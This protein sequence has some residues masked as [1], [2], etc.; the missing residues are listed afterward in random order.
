MAPFTLE[1]KKSVLSHFL[2]IIFMLPKFVMLFVLF[3]PHF[4][5]L[6]QFANKII[7]LTELAVF[8]FHSLNFRTV[9]NDLVFH[10]LFNLLYLSLDNFIQLSVFLAIFKEF[11]DIRILTFPRWDF[12]AIIFIFLRILW[13]SFSRDSSLV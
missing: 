11:S 6:L 7:V 12:Q 5:A 13:D 9:S 3:D 2:D 8:L 1:F 10:C 4:K